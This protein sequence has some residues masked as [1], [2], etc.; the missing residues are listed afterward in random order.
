MDEAHLDAYWYANRKIYISG[1]VTR[2]S[3]SSPNCLYSTQTSGRQSV[4]T[5]RSEDDPNAHSSVCESRTNAAP[6]GADRGERSLEG[7]AVAGK[8]K[9]WRIPSASW[10]EV[11]A[12]RRTQ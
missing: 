3:G 9:G 10:Q 2:S 8:A 4:N 7:A 5:H 12:E 11:I 6:Y 1:T